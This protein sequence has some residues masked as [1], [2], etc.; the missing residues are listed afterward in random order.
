M[1]WGVQTN[2]G[3]IKEQGGAQPNLPGPQALD[4]PSELEDQHALN[5]MNQA[6]EAVKAQDMPGFTSSSMFPSLSI[7]NF[8]PGEDVLRGALGHV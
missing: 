1:S 4:K 7:N 2:S 8:E 3:Q 6:I 5:D